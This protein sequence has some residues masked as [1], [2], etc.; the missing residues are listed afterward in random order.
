[1]IG[2]M[3][4]NKHH[5]NSTEHKSCILVMTKRM[6]IAERTDFQLLIQAKDRKILTKCVE[7]SSCC[8]QCLAVAGQKKELWKFYYVYRV[9][10]S[11]ESQ[12]YIFTQISNSNVIIF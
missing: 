5:E 12:I 10:I 3:A 11:V 4:M 1:M 6:T 7:M 9:N 8:C 2:N